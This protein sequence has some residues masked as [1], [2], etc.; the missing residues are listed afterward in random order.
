MRFRYSFFLIFFTFLYASLI[1]NLYK[2]QI[3]KSFYY[4]QKAQARNQAELAKVVNRGRIFF[5]DRNNN[6]IPVALNRDFPIIYAVPKEIKDPEEIAKV[7]APIIQWDEE[8]LIKALDH[9]S[10]LFRLLV[11]KA[12]ETQINKIKELNLP[13][14]YISSLTHRFYPSQNLGSHVL[15][16]V[17]INE[18]ND[19]PT[20]LYGIERYYQKKLEKGEDIYLTIDRIL[21]TQAESVL[22]DLI[23]KYEAEGGT[24]IIQEPKTGKILALANKPDFDP[25]N[26]SQW[27]IQN[28]TN[29]AV[30]YLYE[31]GSVL[32][33]ITLAAGIDLGVLTPETTYFDKGSVTLNGK[34]ITNWDNKAYGLAT[35][36]NVIER[37]INTGAVFAESKVGHKNFLEYLRKFGFEERTGID[38]PEEVKGN[39]KNL[40]RKEARD[41]D[42]ATASF[43]QGIAVTPLALVNAFSAIANGGL[44]M[45]PYLNAQEKPMVIRRVI[46]EETSKKIIEMMESA[47]EKAGVASISHYR[48][49]GKTGTAQI[50]NL[51]TGG[52]FSDQFIHSYVGLGPASNPRFVILIRLTKPKAELAALTVVPAFKELAQFILNYY[53]IPPDK[54]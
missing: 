20:G 24:V 40:S 2:L 50:P 37:S 44:L 19:F 36:I 15:G 27:P 18:E 33:V 35:M 25:N 21:Q 10:S 54:L 11:D 23:S 43:G 31:P 6:L 32:K 41:I 22:S 28:F 29:P 12:S 16:F 13:G 4:S 1:Y 9:P 42:F 51:K 14:I 46:S 52:Y 38:L 45:K 26:Y 30:Q 49:A 47:V 8:K 34:T 5:T 48:I 7:L 39:L 17:G 3:E 53:H